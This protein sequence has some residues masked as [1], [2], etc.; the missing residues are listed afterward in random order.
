[1]FLVLFATFVF[2]L[3]NALGHSDNFIPANPVQTPPEIVPEWYLLP[4]YA[5]L[6][7]FDFNIGPIDSKTAGV[8]AMFAS[9]GVLFILPW[10]DT[11]RVRSM[12]YRPAA[13]Q[14]FLVFVVVAIALGWCGGQNPGTVL[15]AG[16]QFRA[17]LTWVAGG[18]TVQNRIQVPSPGAYQAA[19][20]AAEQQLR[21][22]HATMTAVMRDSGTTANAIGIIGG[23]VQTRPLVANNADDLETR[24]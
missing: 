14:F 12:R 9:I 1:L 7:A 21:D 3:P 4:F 10:L 23:T 2:F 11:S 22:Q 5:I 13:R 19:A 15:V 24:I 8:F 20:D 16:G 17:T 18:Q 6:R